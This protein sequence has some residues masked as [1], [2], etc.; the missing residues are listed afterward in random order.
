MFF[1]SPN[2]LSD[3]TFSSFFSKH[4]FLLSS[5][6][7][8]VLSLIHLTL[9]TGEPL[10]SAQRK[11]VDCL[12]YL[13]SARWRGANLS[14]TSLLALDCYF[15]VLQ[16]ENASL[17][18]CHLNYLVVFNE[19]MSGSMNALLLPHPARLYICFEES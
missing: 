19:Y 8:S 10:V 11:I 15:T 7:D 9:I 2:S 12:K 18:V 13:Q 6:Q 14:S 3:S 17:N 1:I 5:L 16:L 4:P